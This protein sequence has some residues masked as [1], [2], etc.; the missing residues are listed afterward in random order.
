MKAVILDDEQHCVESLA[1][2]LSKYT[3]AEVVAEFTDSTEAAEKL[4]SLEF[5]VLFIDIEMPHLNGFELLT[6]FPDA[7]WSVIFTTAYDEYAVKA[8]KINAIDYLMKPIASSDLIA[9]VKKVKKT[10]DKVSHLNR[11][12]LNPFKDRME[13]FAIP[14]LAGLEM[15]NVG[16][17][18]Y[19]ASDSNYTHIVLGETKYTASKTLKYFEEILQPFGFI[20]IHYSCLVNPNKIKRYVKGDGGYVIMENGKNLSVSRSRKEELLN[21]LRLLT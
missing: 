4:E 6:L 14:T 21:N 1:T 15:I 19:L 10:R 17:V 16:D 5:D 2:M 11:I 9:A 3:Q 13:K 8:F 7:T 18:E 12:S 20:R